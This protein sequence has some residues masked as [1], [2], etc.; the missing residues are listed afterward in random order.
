MTVMG[1][2]NWFRISSV[3]PQHVWQDLADEVSIGGNDLLI[4]SPNTDS[5]GVVYHFRRA[6]DKWKLHAS[7]RPTENT[8]NLVGFGRSLSLRGDQLL[9][10]APAAD[11]AKGR[12]FV[13]RRD[14]RG[15]W[16]AAMV[17]RGIT[18]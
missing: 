13:V 16:S 7:I 2:P 14:T 6:Q 8:A 10:G 15:E 3:A 1:S 11:S 5:T 4:G 17:N 18:W 9:V 12:V